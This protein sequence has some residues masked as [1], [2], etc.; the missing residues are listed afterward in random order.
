MPFKESLK[1]AI[2][3]YCNNHLADEDWYNEEF[4][5]I[6]DVALRKRIIEEF[7]GIRFAYKLYE[8]LEAKD[9]NL[10][11][12]VRH[13]IFAYATIYE[14]I[15][16]YVLYTYY[17]DTQEFHKIQFHTVPTRM[18]F[19]EQQMTSV[20]TILSQQNE[21][22]YIYHNQERKKDETQV[23][24]DEKCKAAETLG[25]IKKIVTDKGEVIDLPSEIVEIYG[26]RNAIHLVAEQRKGIQYELELSKIAYRR[27][28]PFIDQVKSG[29]KR[30][31]KSI[32]AKDYY[33]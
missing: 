31:N 9:E 14:A 32:F 2:Y 33:E 18:S 15:I 20:K 3:D 26:Y 4:E 27:M 29:L 24:F 23:R 16:H 5:F 6:E 25:L 13:Q 21:Q 28:R 30:D 22:I 12:E 17:K 10:V 8:G 7:K 1:N 11:F 19:C